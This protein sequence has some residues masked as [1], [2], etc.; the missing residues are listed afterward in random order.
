MAWP[1]EDPSGSSYKRGGCDQGSRVGLGSLHNPHLHRGKDKGKKLIQAGNDFRA[2]VRDRDERILGVVGKNYHPVQNI[3]AFEFMDAAAGSG[4]VEY[5]TAGSLKNGR[6]VWI[7]AK[8]PGMIKILPKDS[9]DKYLLLYQAHDG[10]MAV[11]IGLTP[12]RVVC[13]NTLSMAHQGVESGKDRIATIRHTMNASQLLKDTAKAIAEAEAVFQDAANGW[14]FIAKVKMSAGKL[15]EYIS[16]LFPYP[17]PKSDGTLPKDSFKAIR[18]R[19]KE[20]HEAGAGADIK[21]VR[22]TF[23]GGYNAVA[24]VIDHERGK[25]DDTRLRSQWFGNGAQIKQRAMSLALAMASN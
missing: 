20:L 22:G 17:A 7:L 14:R 6:W 5:H 16:T 1:G 4:L 21:G 23:W 2:V 19:I 9:I 13:W 11:R 18:E 12:I 10:S 3:D 24:E 25:N 8:L 15:D